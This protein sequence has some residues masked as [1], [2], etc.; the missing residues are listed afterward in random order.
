M[1]LHGEWNHTL[2]SNFT[3]AGVCLHPGDTESTT[4]ATVNKRD[5]VLFPPFYEYFSRSVGLYRDEVNF[6]CIHSLSLNEWY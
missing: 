2:Y 3:M 1:E 4:C 5:K 6:S